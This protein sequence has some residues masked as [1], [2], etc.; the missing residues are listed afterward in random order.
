MKKFIAALAV[1]TA[2]LVTPAMANER[3]SSTAAAQALVDK[4]KEI[5]IIS[6]RDPSGTVIMVYANL[7]T[8]TVTAFAGS[9][10]RVCIVSEG[11]GAM[12]GA[13]KKSRVPGKDGA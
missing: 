2:L 13:P 12:I 10:D 1:S 8:G 7:D 4:F 5:P 11:E 6:W 3:C 9:G